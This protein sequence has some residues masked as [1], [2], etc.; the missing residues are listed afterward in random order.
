MATKKK[1]TDVIDP[2]Q[3]TPPVDTT[4][5][6]QQSQP[7]QDPIKVQ[8]STKFNN[9]GTVT[10]GKNGQEMTLSKE[11]YNTFL[12][13]QGSESAARQQQ[14]QGF[15]TNPAIQ[16]FTQNLER[17]RIKAKVAQ[18]LAAGAT[19]QQIQNELLQEQV[20]NQQAQTDQSQPQ[21]D[22][23]A[24]DNRTLGQKYLDYQKNYAE[25]AVSQNLITS[26]GREN[27]KNSLIQK[28]DQGLKTV[29]Q[30]YDFAYS[31]TQGGKGI[32]QREAEQ[33][34]NQVESSF[35]QDIAAVEAGLLDASVVQKKIDLA[36]QANIRLAESVK[37]LG[38]YNL[39]YWLTDGKEVETLLV[40]NQGSL[41][42][43]KQRLAQAQAKASFGL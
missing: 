29:A 13:S 26:S 6:Q 10:V 21:Q 5:Q 7:Q 3:V 30:L 8:T 17:A 28:R 25:Q 41:D 23:Q 1:K 24:P 38:K 11:Q 18:G 22:V 9:D 40:V 35:S 2:T 37:G 14:V 36:Q 19:L 12:A 43:Y 33:T 4:Q 34:F 15:A 32:N 20:K 27:I 31:L 16:E 39:R 42:N